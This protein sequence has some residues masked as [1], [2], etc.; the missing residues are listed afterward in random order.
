MKP[1]LMELGKASV[2]K[3]DVP[4]AIQQLSES[5]NDD[6]F[7]DEALFMLGACLQAKGMNGLSAVVTSAAID[8]RL[9]EKRNFPEAL[10]NLGAAYKAEHR[11]DVAERIWREALSHETIPRER[12]KILCNLSGL[13]VNE[14]QPEKAIELCNRALAEDPKCYN[15]IANRGMA[16][17]ELGNWREGWDGWRATLE[18]GDRAQRIYPG[19][20]FGTARR[21]EGDRLGRSGRRR[22]NL[23]CLLHRRYDRAM[24]GEGHFRLSPAATDAFR[25]LISRHRNSRHAQGFD[26]AALALRMRC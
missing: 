8:A 9:N 24:R 11:N 25:A 15:A 5:L 4:L 20:R 26:G 16:N 1:S 21:E 17:L 10:M 19:S 6:F 3:G 22:R 12:A 2:A 18:T 14:G 13:F 23:L 7:N